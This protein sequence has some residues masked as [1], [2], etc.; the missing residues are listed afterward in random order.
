MI[1]ITAENRETWEKTFDFA[2]EIKA[3]KP[4][5]YFFEDMIFGIEDPESKTIYFCSIMGRAGE[6]YSIN[7]Y[8]GWQG[9][10]NFYDLNDWISAGAP[11]TIL[12]EIQTSIMIE[13]ESRDFLEKHDTYL[14][15]QLKRKYRGKN[16]WTK[17]Q[18]FTPGLFP[19]IITDEQAAVLARI[20]PK[21][22]EILKAAPQNLDFTNPIKNGQTKGNLLVYTQQKNDWQTQW[23]D[24]AEHEPVSTRNRTY[25]LEIEDTYLKA[26]KI[27]GKHK[28]TVFTCF[29]GMMPMPIQEKA[30]DRPNYSYVVLWMDSGSDFILGVE[31][32]TNL[33]EAKDIQASVEMAMNKYGVPNGVGFVEADI[34]SMAAPALDVVGVEPLFDSENEIAVKHFLLEVFA[35]MMG[36]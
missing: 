12:L 16:Q 8:K 26:A 24:F 20:L 7:L 4:W 34:I 13:F 6:S 25:Q 30:S 9:L 19:W 23:L 11:N 27:T 21:I 3:M 10:K 2:D 29:T 35:P 15:K 14:I 32:F 33:P 17:F 18:D 1:K 28:D 31:T 22:T 36:K 5:T